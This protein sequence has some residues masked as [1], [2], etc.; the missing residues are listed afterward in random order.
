MEFLIAH[1]PSTPLACTV[2]IV[3]SIVASYVI[4][5]FVEY[6]FHRYL[7]HEGLPE[8]VYRLVPYLRAV[9]SE[10]RLHHRLY[11]QQRFDYEPDPV[12]Y[13]LNLRIH[14]HHSAE[15][16]RYLFRTLYSR[17][18]TFLLSR[19]LFSVYLRCCTI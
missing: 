11:Y 18:I 16:R 5:S 2:Q 17:R 15:V 10:H 19:R 7:M 8:W 14:W 3:G 6:V 4:I 13:E 1:F 12:G 9:L